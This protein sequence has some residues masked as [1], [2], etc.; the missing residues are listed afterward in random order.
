MQLLNHADTQPVKR[1]KRW[2]GCAI[3]YDIKFWMLQ[4]RENES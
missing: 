4:V 3:I 1:Y 2:K